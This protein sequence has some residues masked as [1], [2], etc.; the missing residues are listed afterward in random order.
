MPVFRR[1][2]LYSGFF[3]SGFCTPV[4]AAISP[5][6]AER[7]HLSNAEIGVYFA[8]Q[9]FSSFLSSAIATR[10]PI[11]SLRIGFLAFGSGVLL[12][13]AASHAISLGGAALIGLGIGF[14]NTA[15]NAVRAYSEDAAAGLLS[16]NFVWSLGTVASAY[17]FRNAAVNLRHALPIIGAIAVLHA[18]WWLRQTSFAATERKNSVSDLKLEVLFALALF[19]Y[20]GAENAI[21]MWTKLLISRQVEGP[22]PG[23]ALTAFTATMLLGRLASPFLMKKLGIS[24]RALFLASITGGATCIL[25]VPIAHLATVQAVL[26]AIAGWMIAP[27]FPLIVY[28]FTRKLAQERAWAFCISGLGASFLPYAM[29]LLSM[30]VGLAW[31][32]TVPAVALLT[33]LAVVRSASAIEQ[34][35]PAEILNCPAPAE[36]TPASSV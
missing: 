19:C 35:A 32:F 30:R 28:E 5:W 16:L 4:I 27:L 17:F 24:A 6:L 31:S 21:A 18:V 2:A 25:L 20:V 15:S 10:R 7:D 33:V 11:W 1:T 8:I 26:I 14:V 22:L 34:F 36:Q 13:P 9:F 23:I 3:Y 29:G 12:L